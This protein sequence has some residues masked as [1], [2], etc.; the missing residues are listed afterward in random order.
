MNFR[1]YLALLLFQ[2]SLFAAGA[3]DLPPSVL[4]ELAKASRLEAGRL[5]MSQL[6]RAVDSGE[7]HLRITPGEYYFTGELPALALRGV[8]DFLIEAE[9]VTFWICPNQKAIELQSCSGIKIS[10]LTIDYDPLPYVQGR[11][12]RIDAQAHR[13][14][15][16]VT[17]GFPLPSERD[18]RRTGAVKA[19]FY[20]ADGKTMRKVGLDW[21]SVFRE[22]HDRL[23]EVGFVVGRVFAP[24]SPVQ[25]GDIL[26][27]P[28]RD[29]SHAIVSRDC[30]GLVFQDITLY[31]SGSMGFVEEGGGGGNKYSHCR[32]VPRPGTARVLAC[33]ADVFHSLAVRHGPLIEGCEFSHAGDDFINVHGYFDGVARVVGTREIEI[34]HQFTPAFAAGATVAV[35]DPV[36]LAIRAKSRVLRVKGVR[37]GAE[38][39]LAAEKF[40]EDA[41][42]H[43]IKIRDF[44]RPVVLRISLE[45]DVS[46][47]RGDL[48]FLPEFSGAGT[49]LRGNHLHDTICRGALVGGE[50]LLVQDNVIERTGMA[51]LVLGSERYWLEA[52]P[53][54][55]VR[56]ENNQLIDC[57]ISG[58]DAPGAIEIVTAG[59]QFSLAGGYTARAVNVTHNT[60]VRP[61]ACGII[62][63]G[64]EGGCLAHNKII[65]PQARLASEGRDQRMGNLRFAISAVGWRDLQTSANE[66]A[67]PS[68]ATAGCLF[69]SEFTNAKLNR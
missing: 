3:T 54:D 59:T 49:V 20:D 10:G 4:S 39:A 68:P 14:E 35:V 55:E 33:N 60:I 24:G 57:G 51:G 6:K 21:M 26:A 12:R 31:A 27:L 62:G 53:P 25:P 56:I 34:V 23:Y 69:Q 15:I 37:A 17:R 13:I 67:E 42:R 5:L 65:A 63:Y 11:V 64:V 7:K 66:L 58:H 48:L 29:Q 52:R 44:V 16:E 1:T 47:D 45:T 61:A 36:T 18:A 30:E 40:C 38:A 2:V 50:N 22:R 8:S 32:V 19:I 41:L 43:G 9:G 46:T 28:N